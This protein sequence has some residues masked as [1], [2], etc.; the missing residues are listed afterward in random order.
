M[1]ARYGLAVEVIETF[2]TGVT[3]DFLLKEEEFKELRT[4]H[5]KSASDFY[6]ML[7]ALLGKEMDLAFPAEP[8]IR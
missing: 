7:G 4:R 8:F 1:E 3:E 6:G 2:H 5:L